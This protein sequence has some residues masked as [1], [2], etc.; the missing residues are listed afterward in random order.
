MRTFMNCNRVTR[1]R[2][3]SSHIFGGS[4]ELAEVTPHRL[5]EA[6]KPRASF[7]IPLM[8]CRPNGEIIAKRFT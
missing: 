7:S 4:T 6:K 2:R 5:S 8:V 3:E 1:S